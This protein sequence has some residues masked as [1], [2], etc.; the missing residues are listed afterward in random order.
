MNRIARWF[1]RPKAKAEGT[2]RLSAD[3]ESDKTKPVTFTSELV[4]GEWTDKNNKLHR[5]KVVWEDPIAYKATVGIAHNVWDSWF[6]LRKEIGDEEP[7]PQNEA[8]QK[9]LKAIN[10]KFWFTQQLISERAHGWGAMYTGPNTYRSEAKFGYGVGGLDV[11]T[12]IESEFPSNV[13]DDDGNP[14]HLRVKWNAHDGS[15]FDDIEMKDIIWMCTR[16]KGRE[17]DGYSAMHMVWDD[18]TYLRSSK[19]SLNFANQKYGLGM[20]MWP[21]IGALTQE[22]LDDTEAAIQDSGTMR[23]TIVERQ[24]FEMPQFIGPPA[25]GTNNIVVGIDTFLGQVAAGTDIPKPMYLGTESG[26]ISGSEINSEQLFA[27]IS[28]IQSDME[29]YIRELIKRMNFEDDFVIDWNVRPAIDKLKAAQTRMMNAQAAAMEMRTE[30]GIG[31]NDIA[32]RFQEGQ[33]DQEDQ[34][35]PKDPEKENNPTGVQAK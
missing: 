3:S 34:E 13:Y 31:A 7:H 15:K 17:W 6:V 10:A 8:I 9:E 12:P 28:R 18:M 25:S 24:K 20:F 23:A 33:E 30:Q 26:A 4:T 21:L 19:H 32:I 16:P 35:G 14:T 2:S 1:F 5:Q 22:I 27:T 29:P 11:F